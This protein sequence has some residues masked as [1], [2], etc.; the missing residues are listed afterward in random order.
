MHMHRVPACLT[1]RERVRL[2]AHLTYLAG[3]PLRRRR[4]SAIES[5]VASTANRILAICAELWLRRAFRLFCLLL[6]SSA[7]QQFEE[8]KVRLSHES[9]TPVDRTGRKAPTGF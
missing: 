3:E 8:V 9:E 1:I 5:V 7:C 6:A 2:E 4:K